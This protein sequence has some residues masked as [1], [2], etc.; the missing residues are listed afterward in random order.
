MNI[1]LDTSALVKRYVKESGTDQ[2][3]EI[4]KNADQIFVSILAIPETFSLIN[5]LKREKNLEAAEYQRLK[6][7]IAQDFSNLQICELSPEVIKESIT[8]LEHHQ[9]KTLDALQL[10]CALICATQNFISAD[11]Q[12]L[13]IAMKLNLGTIIL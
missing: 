9:I 8:I 5:R 10:S 11:Q 13:A 2:L 12:Q 7:L 1:F 6:N 3:L 4:L